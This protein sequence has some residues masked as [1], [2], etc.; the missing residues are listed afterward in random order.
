MKAP[1]PARRRL[2]ELLVERGLAPSR[3]QAKLAILAGKVRSGTTVLDKAG[4][5]YPQDI[6]LELIQPSPYVSRGGEKLAGFLEKFPLPLQDLRVLDAG[7]STGGFTDYL[8]QH[9]VAEVTCV[10]VGYGQLHYKL[11]QD[12]RVTNLERVNVRQLD[13]VSLPH[14][15]YDL[16]VMDLSFISLTKVLPAVWN[17]VAPG[18]HLVA[19]VKPQFEAGKAE[20]DAGQGVIRDPAVHAR[21]LEEVRAFVAHLLPAATEFGFTESPL[22]GADGNTEFFLGWKKVAN[23]SALP[24]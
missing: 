8:L 24:R 4:Q 21:V 14:P 19:L 7:A 23:P 2:D 5:L 9:G 20:A 17:R 6:P 18:G 10:D 16:A 11:R 22:K 12:P 15:L 1:R 13:E 3:A